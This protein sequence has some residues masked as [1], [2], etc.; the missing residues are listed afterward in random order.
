MYK[1]IKEAFK[2]PDKKLQQQRLIQW[3]K[4][5]SV[6]RIESPTNLTKARALG[7]KAKQ[8]VILVRVRM[9]R[10]G[11][12]RPQIKK[13]RR[14]KH[15]HQKLILGKS[16]QWVS[17][18]RA[19]KKFPNMEVLNSY[20]VGKDGKSYWFEVILVDPCHPAIESSKNMQWIA[21]NKAHNRVYKGKT[22]AGRRSRGLH[23][24]GK[25]REKIRPSLRANK[26]TA[27]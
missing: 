20:K 5:N 17:E 23:K 16:Y 8:G 22:S 11:K 1:Y 4:E 19:Q 10:G 3:R 24:K 12:Q 9:K 13:G 25:G 14:P 26:R 27:K 6:T 2:K 21:R 15:Y 18:E 7:Y